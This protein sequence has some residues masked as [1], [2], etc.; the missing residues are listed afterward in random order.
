MIDCYAQDSVRR[1][2]TP[3]E[4]EDRLARFLYRILR[5]NFGELVGAADMR[6]YRSE[7][8]PYRQIKFD[9]DVKYRHLTKLGWT[10]WRRLR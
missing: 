2:E 1:G 5:D 6:D 4:A 9:Y 10:S 8:E 7:Y 3:E